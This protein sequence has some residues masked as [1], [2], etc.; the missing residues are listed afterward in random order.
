MR[1]LMY[2][3]VA[4]C[5]LVTSVCGAGVQIVSSPKLTGPARYGIGKLS[6]AFTD[7]GLRVETLERPE[8]ATG[9]HV[10]VAGLASDKSLAAWITE[11]GLALPEQPESLAVR[12]LQNGDRHT[13]VLCGAD[14][15]GLMYAA[16]D[17]AQRIRWAA[18]DQHLFAQIRDTSESPCLADRSVSTYTMQRRW[19]EQRLHDPSYWEQYFD[20]LAASR[21]NSYAIIFGYECGGFMAPLY[22]YFFDVEEFPEVELTGI[23]DQQ[24]ARNAAALQRVIQ[25]AHERGIRITVGIWDHIYRGGVQG[26]GIAGASE[27]GWQAGASSGLRGHR[28]ESGCL[29]ESRVEKTADRFSRDRRDPV[30]HALGIGAHAGRNAAFLARSVCD[31]ARAAI[32]PS[33]STC[34]PRGCRMR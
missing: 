32:P 33:V 20:M 11:A 17:A 28:R 15:V 23:T 34:G 21:I 1:L 22:P 13:V 24:Q 7:R 2:F 25:L 10:I 3:F 31:A 12:Q 27:L 30:P 18:D 4:W 8:Q 6:D 19:F 14:P 29:H 26:G 5:A 16:L 9:T